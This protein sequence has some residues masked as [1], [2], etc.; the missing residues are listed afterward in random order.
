MRQ[1]SF[2]RDGTV[3]APA[4][5]MRLDAARSVE[6]RSRISQ[7]A[8]GL[9]VRKGITMSK[10]FSK[11]SLLAGTVMVSAVLAS[12][13][14]AQADDQ[15]QENPVGT[16]IDADA[17]QD[18]ESIVVTGSR[19]QR[20]DLTSTSPL[21]VVQDE[22]FKLSGAVNVEQVINTLPQVVPGTTSFSNNPGGGV[23]TLNLR[24]IGAA[25]TLVLV[26]GRRWV[27]FDPQQI[28]DLN[29]IPQFLLDS[30]DVV[31]GGAS[32][33]YGSDA[34][35]GVVNFRLKQN[36]S[37]I[38]AGGQYGIT[39]NGDGARYQGFVAI[40]ASTD[41]GRGNVTAF[42]EYYNRKP[43]FQGAR[44]FSRFALGDD[45]TGLSPAGSPTTPQGRVSVAPTSVV[46][47]DPDGPTGPL[48]APTLPR[49]VGNFGTTF[50]ANFGSPGVS[51]VFD[52]PGD[53]YNYAPA[54]YLQV[55]QE[56]YMIGGYGHYDITDSVTAFV[57][58]VFVNNRVANELAA[59]PVGGTFNVNL[60]A[61]QAY[62]SPADFATLQQI[63]ANETA[64]NAARA[65]AGLPLLF[66]PVAGGL[67]AQAPGIV[68]LGIGRRILETGAR[69]TLDERNAFRLLAGVRGPAFADWTYEAYYSY[70]RTRNANIQAG[71]I[72][73]SAYRRAVESGA[74]N[75]FG[76]GTLSQDDVDS[77]SILAQ[78]GEISTLQVASASL[79]GTLGNFGLGAEDIGVALG[80][81]YRKVAAEFLPD[82]ALS[83]GD[84][85]GFNAGDPTEGDYNVKEVFGEIRVPLISD[86]PF[87]HRLELNG[88]ARYSDYSLEAVGSTWTYAG[89]AEWA[90]VPD[91]TFRGQYQRAVRAPNVGELFGGQSNGFPGATD[92]CALA[93]AATNA[94]IRDLCIA[95]GVP[96][97]LVG[98]PGLQPA[99][100]IQ[101]LFGGNPDLEEEVSDTYTV[102]AVIRPSFIPRLNISVDY[103]NIKVENYIS[104]L[105]GGLNGT[106][107][108]CY[109][110]IQDINS[111]YC[112][113]IANGGRNPANGQIGDNNFLPLI[114]NAN[115]AKIETSGVD[116]QVDY[117]LPLS[118]G[119]YGDQSKLNF[120]FLGTYTETFKFFAVQQLDTFNECA[121]RFG[122]LVCGNPQPKW[123]WTSRLSYIDGP[124]TLSGRWRHL[125]ATQ[126][127]DDSTDYVVESLEAYDL[128]DLSL[129]FDIT[130]NF[131]LA[132]GVNN[133]LDKQ[134]QLIGDNQEQANTYPGVFDVLG[135][136]Y[137]VSVNM[138]F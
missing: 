51:D 52:F 57:E 68:Q 78:N 93:G 85:I 106:L 42:A 33:V 64:I 28:V 80:A 82:T 110:A 10:V 22:E 137:F 83:S 129:G 73:S 136:D 127:D 103:F 124:L 87:F 120:F 17:G 19:I 70:A 25:R 16:D 95:T 55:P 62:L 18:G 29:T 81:E 39:E 43:I 54:N 36:L 63:D 26:N 11:A 30:V 59:T 44:D 125:S 9:R 118:F 72:S 31:T 27:S 123:K 99:T 84:V 35:S 126:D 94:T 1:F 96:A 20:R 130:E 71:N 107:N 74:I 75:V 114:G 122:Q 119:M 23:A 2:T 108:L 56:R 69:N 100:Q 132:M 49:G 102:G 41:D 7:G 115:V 34:L 86:A 89:G 45:G 79:S 111:V 15:V 134:P 21:A 58:A 91:I 53:L 8:T 46:G 66:G 113:A 116:M 3:I 61:S 133:I 67:N 60:A 77:I 128:F 6:A 109:N 101:G 138:K 90:P 5:H 4:L 32:A 50:G 76:P 47:M 131:S 112:Q 65:A 105:G 98:S 13:A 48:T 97:G 117:S 14:F 135:R 121:G 92:P 38:E 104:T 24:G 40:G 88:A 37:G 12:P